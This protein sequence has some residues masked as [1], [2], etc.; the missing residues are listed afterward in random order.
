MIEKTNSY[1]P[2][3]FDKADSLQPPLVI[4]EVDRKV[5][6]ISFDIFNAQFTHLMSKGIVYAVLGAIAIAC[7]PATLVIS[8]PSIF[9][10]LIPFAVFTVPVLTVVTCIGAAVFIMEIAK[11]RKEL[12]YEISLLYTWAQ[13]KDWWNPI[14]KDIILGGIP[15]GSDHAGR[16]QQQEEI[17]A[18]LTMLEDFELEKGAVQPISG[19]Q[20]KQRG[21]NHCHIQAVDFIGVPAEKIHEGVQFLEEQIKDGKKVYVHCKAG[22]GRS[23]AIVL[24]YLLKQNYNGKMIDFQHAYTEVHDLVKAK[25]PQINLNANQRQTIQEYYE[26]FVVNP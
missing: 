14:T 13:G 21:I 7:L 20:W 10:T 19:E 8:I 17:G 2:E 9:A 4:D 23:V 26:K 3:I 24:A 6:Q 12:K 25:R 16:L 15:L 5:G 22:R 18:V 1:F 11:K